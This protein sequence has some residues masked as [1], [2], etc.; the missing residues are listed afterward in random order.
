MGK[1]S[2]SA[3]NRSLVLRCLVERLYALDTWAFCFAMQTKAS[4]QFSTRS[5]AVVCGLFLSQVSFAQAPEAQAES[6]V[7]KLTQGLF[8][9]HLV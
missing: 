1:R 7:S 3:S 8:R 6:P 4:M 2:T 5:V 9:A